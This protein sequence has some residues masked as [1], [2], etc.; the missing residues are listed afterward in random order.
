[1]GLAKLVRVK[2]KDRPKGAWAP[3]VLRNFFL[4][5]I[6]FIFVVGDGMIHVCIAY[7]T[8]IEEN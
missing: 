6:F 8:Y 3:L 2:S 4:L 1:M 7:K 5:V